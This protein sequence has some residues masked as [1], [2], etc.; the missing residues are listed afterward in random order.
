V[1]G[2]DGLFVDHA[3]LNRIA[4]DLRGAV[5]AIDARLDR[6]EGELAPLRTEWGGQARDA[7]AVAKAAWDGA[8]LEMRAVLADTSRAVLEA[9]TRYAQSDRSAAAA[10]Q[11]L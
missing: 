8:M 3:A 9:N 11:Q 10:F 5:G 7:Y 4:D 1:N 6:L 2:G